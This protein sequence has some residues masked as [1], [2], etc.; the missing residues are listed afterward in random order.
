MAT[1]LLKI[2]QQLLNEAKKIRARRVVELKERVNFHSS[3]LK[4]SSLKI[5]ANTN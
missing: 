3:S 5:C 2:E 4:V 1:T